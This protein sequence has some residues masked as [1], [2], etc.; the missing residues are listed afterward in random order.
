MANQDSTK[1]SMMPERKNEE[2]Y[3]AWEKRWENAKKKERVS[4]LGKRMFKA[5]KEILG[6]TLEDLKIEN[7]IE[8]GCGLGN[9]LEVFPEKGIPYRGIDISLNAVSFCQKRGF[10]AI[11]KNVEDVVDQYDLVSSDGMLEHF[12]DFEPYAKHMMKISKKYV[13]LIQPNYDSFLGKTLAYL[14]EIFR[15]HQ[16]VYEY[17]YRIKDFIDVFERNDFKL[18]RNYPIFFNVFRLLLFKKKYQNE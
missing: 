13:L 16:N 4:F 10:H 2:L 11:Q 3:T 18:F 1:D 17:N 5:K 12:L 6:K 7:A 8:I 9:T 14:A 15:S